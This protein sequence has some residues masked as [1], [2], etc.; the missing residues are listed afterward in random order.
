MVMNP[1]IKTAAPHINMGLPVLNQPLATDYSRSYD[2]PEAGVG[3]FEFFV[4]GDIVKIV[5]MDPRD[6]ISQEMPAQDS[7][8]SWGYAKADE[9]L[10]KRDS[11]KLANNTYLKRGYDYSADA[12]GTPVIHVQLHSTNII[13]FYPDGTISLNT[14]GW[15]TVTTMAR[16]RQ[17]SPVHIGPNKGEWFVDTPDGPVEFSD[18]MRFDARG[19]PVGF[20]QSS[21]PHLADRI[22]QQATVLYLDQQGR[23][24]WGNPGDRAK[25]KVQFEDGEVGFVKGEYLQMVK[26]SMSGEQREQRMQI[27]SPFPTSPEGEA[28]EEDIL[29]AKRNPFKKAQVNPHVTPHPTSQP[30]QPEPEFGEDD[31]VRINEDAD[32][33]LVGKKFHISRREFK[34]SGAGPEWHYYGT[35]GAD[36]G[37]SIDQTLYEFELEALESPADRTPVPQV[38][39]QPAKYKVGDRLQPYPPLDEPESTPDQSFVVKE[40]RQDP[41]YQGGWVY[42]NEQGTPYEEP[43]VYLV[44]QTPMDEEAAFQKRRDDMM[45]KK[46]WSSRNPFRSAQELK[47]DIHSDETETPSDSD[48]SPGHNLEHVDRT[49][50]VSNTKPSHHQGPMKSAQNLSKA[51]ELQSIIDHGDG[52]LLR[53]MIFDYSKPE[54]VQAII[55]WAEGED[56]YSCFGPERHYVAGI[57]KKLLAELQGGQQKQ[58]QSDS[59]KFKVGDSVVF[60]DPRYDAEERFGVV[61]HAEGYAD[62]D[63]PI[64]SIRADDGSTAFIKEAY[65]RV[66]APN[67]PKYVQRE[68]TPSADDLDDLYKSSRRNPFKPAQLSATPAEMTDGDTAETGSVG[69]SESNTGYNRGGR[70]PGDL[71]GPPNPFAHDTGQN[72]SGKQL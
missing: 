44:P 68:Q 1:F 42:V 14:G 21:D 25:Y 33:D 34:D 27:V 40:V 69:G 50:D 15:K 52:F 29:I 4:E 46:L 24:K 39:P 22:G 66:N 3:D 38:V 18:G 54:D 10:G 2:N 36:D 57:A 17:F 64:Y 9:M 26:P 20:K 37:S 8:N 67:V 16:I 43:D 55:K 19:L 32:E 41:N 60:S 72:S 5:G 62:D 35:V 13:T 61:T 45:R 70:T 48:S 31:I 53:G 49:D 63:T 65:I 71:S 28:G 58:A 56:G 6:R 12:D 11:R 23:G 59:H 7:T 47:N 51:E 30:M